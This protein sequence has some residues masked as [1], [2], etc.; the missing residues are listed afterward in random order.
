MTHTTTPARAAVTTID[1]ARV[2]TATGAR[3]DGPGAVELM[4]DSLE[5]ALAHLHA[6]DAGVAPTD[7]ERAHAHQ[8]WARLDELGE[9][10]VAAS[11]L[12]GWWC[13][14]DP[15]HRPATRRR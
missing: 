5:T 10:L 12:S 3:T 13:D 14:D 1:R 6:I 11:M 8:L 9:D 4:L 2:A 7:A 15:G